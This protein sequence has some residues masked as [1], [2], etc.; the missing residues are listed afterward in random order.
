MSSKG[1][2]F[3]FSPFSPFSVKALSKSSS[4]D[5]GVSAKDSLLFT[6]RDLFA[7]CSSLD[8]ADYKRKIEFHSLKPLL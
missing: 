5:L 7:L 8:S 4:E 3:D 6:F 1:D 2:K